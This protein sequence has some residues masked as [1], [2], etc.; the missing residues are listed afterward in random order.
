MERTLDRTFDVGS[1]G[2]GPNGRLH[3]P[4]PPRRKLESA[5]LGML[6]LL[7][8]EAMLF[9]GM[10]G[11]CL[12][13]RGVGP[14]PPPDLPRLPWVVTAANTLALI[15]SAFVLA[16]GMQ[17]PRRGR[18]LLAGF[19]GLFFCC[20]QATEWA[21]MLHWRGVHGAYGGLFYTV[22][23]THALHVLGGVLALL[24]AAV[25]IGQPRDA[26]RLKVCGMYWYFV[27]AVWPFIYAMVYH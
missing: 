10:L 18:V 14:W 19:L 11:A 27:V 3:H 7:M 23:G 20:V 16:S 6:L 26:L 4:I 21:R 5:V 9:A 1:N 15:C 2:R 25:K 24:W 13:M 17:G 8:A 22:I 12:M